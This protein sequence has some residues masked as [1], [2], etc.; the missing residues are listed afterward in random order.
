MKTDVSRLRILRRV[1]VKLQKNLSDILG[2]DNGLLTDGQRDSWLHITF[3]CRRGGINCEKRL[4]ALSC[5]PV[6]MYVG[7]PESIEPFWISREPIAWLWCNLAA[8]QR[9]S[10][11]AYVN[12][13]SPVG[14]VSRQW[15]AVDWACVLCDLRVHNHR[16]SRSDNVPAHSTALVQVFFWQASH[17]PDLSAPL[18]TRFGSL[19]LLAFPKDKIAFARKRFVVATVREEKSLGKT[20]LEYRTRL[21]GRLFSQKTQLILD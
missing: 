2:V 17:H 8:S 13:H 7:C 19:R 21:I 9:T 14:L 20:Y 15:D 4:L 3:V 10:Y 6:R 16:A 5:L 1:Y 11:C 18:Q 12:S